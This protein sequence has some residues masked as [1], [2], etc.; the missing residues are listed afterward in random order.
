M[1]KV[2]VCIATYRRPEGLKR[3]LNALNKLT[4][5][6]CSVP[7]LEVIVVDNDSTGSAHSIC[8][9]VRSNFR[10]ILQYHIES[11]RGISYVRNRAISCIST[12]SNFVAFIDDDE[13]PA[14]QWLDELLLVQQQY[15][16]DVVAGPVVPYFS[17]KNTPKWIIRGK[18]FDLA[19]FPTGHS[20]QVAFTG[21][22]LIQVELLKKLDK[23]FDERF[24]LTG[25]ED[26]NFFM[27][28]HHAGY[29]MVW[30][31]DAIVHEWIPRTRTNLVWLLKRGYRT[32]STQTL[33]EREFKPIA[34]LLPKRLAT[35]TARILIGSLLFIP[36]LFL[37]R[38][39]FAKALLQICR[40]AGLLSGL[41][42][43]TY[44]EYKDATAN[45]ME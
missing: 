34:K 8:E 31:D 33:C 18:F 36:S 15:N 23:L 38:H 30:S 16:A 10:W 44:E 2:S 41:A 25:G 5:S 3:L 29:S 35:G 12:Q 28:I 19:R 17:D 32:Y 14:P 20:L 45:P 21:N 39:I 26:T 24:A 40:G 27:R 13:V 37:G 4:F 6:K 9:G 42:G 1:T 11:N 43:R 22:V 7:D